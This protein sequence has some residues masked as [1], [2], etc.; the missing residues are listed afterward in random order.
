M[1]EPQTTQ[2]RVIR[3]MHGRAHACASRCHSSSNHS[4]T[5][6]H[7]QNRS[8]SWVLTSIA[9]PPGP[10]QFSAACRDEFS[11]SGE[12]WLFLRTNR[13]E[14]RCR[15]R[16]SQAL[17]LLQHVDSLRGRAADT[18][19]PSHH[20]VGPE[21]HLCVCEKSIRRCQH[22]TI[23][24]GAS[25]V[26]QPVTTRRPERTWPLHDQLLAWSGGCRSTSCNIQCRPAH[27]CCAPLL[28]QLLRISH[29]QPPAPSSVYRWATRTCPPSRCCQLVASADQVASAV[30]QQHRFIVTHI[31]FTDLLSSTEHVDLRRRAPGQRDFASGQASTSSR[32]HRRLALTCAS[33]RPSRRIDMSSGPRARAVTAMCMA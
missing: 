30:T 1:C 16:A 15:I 21:H 22:V 12:R 27:C 28:R 8:H 7:L 17:D 24:T 18:T 26:G 29:P 6:V 9:A 14:P 4:T 19:V 5:W 32:P 10:L 2:D 31:H 11:Q 33:A 25:I 23:V 13:R 3:C 20:P